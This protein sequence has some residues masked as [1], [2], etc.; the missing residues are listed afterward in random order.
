MSSRCPERRWVL[1]AVALWAVT[2]GG[3]ERERR[4]FHDR[5]PGTPA[6]SMVRQSD[7]Q[8]GPRTADAAVPSPY[9]DNAY[10]VSEGKRLFNQYNCSGC[11]F[12]GGG[13]IGPPLMDAE[14]IYGS[15]PQNIFATIVEGR[16]NGMPSFRHRI[17]DQQ[18]WQLV[19][20]VR[21]MSGLLAKDV[22]PGR[23]D[24][25]QVTAQEQQTT[26][27]HPVKSAVPPSTQRP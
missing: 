18:V 15:E 20:Y 2:L 24:D 3:C 9:D 17:P 27:E 4:G 22:A 6:L 26:K 16:P 21:S 1:G 7:L 5:V 19:A 10:A 25:M 12:Q 11:H 23:S 13:G 14:W 8:P